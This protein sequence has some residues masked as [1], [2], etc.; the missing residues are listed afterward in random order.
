MVFLYEI[1]SLITK[2][3]DRYCGPEQT[4]STKIQIKNQ[5]S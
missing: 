5:D 1:F 3:M 2:K 4:K